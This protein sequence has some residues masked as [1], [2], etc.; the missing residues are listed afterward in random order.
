MRVHL[1]ARMGDSREGHRATC[2]GL[3]RRRP[4]RRQAARD[5][6]AIALL[7]VRPAQMYAALLRVVRLSQAPRRDR[8]DEASANRPRGL[9]RPPSPTHAANA[10]PPGHV[11]CRDG[12]RRRPRRLGPVDGPR[13]RGHRAMGGTKPQPTRAAS[14]NA[15]IEKTPKARG[16]PGTKGRRRRVC[17][18]DL[19]DADRRSRVARRDAGER[20]GARVPVDP[21]IS[22]H[23]VLAHARLG[24]VGRRQHRDR[25]LVAARG[26]RSPAPCG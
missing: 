3:S 7:R 11:A 21:W 15:A 8:G 22:V 12:A 2:D 26:R 24:D 18:S 17:D 4:G 14:A 9:G 19:L 6:V 10:E 1:T 20:L 16:A 23:P 5:A 13:F 25:Y